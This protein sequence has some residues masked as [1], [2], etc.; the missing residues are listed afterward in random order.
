MA[1]KNAR[2][3][4]DVQW[5]GRIPPPFGGVSLIP[6]PSIGKHLGMGKLASLLGWDLKSPPNPSV[7]PVQKNL[8]S[9]CDFLG[10]NKRTKIH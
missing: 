9:I 2:R 1:V 4:G 6:P 8:T 10:C 7:S 3:D 5:E